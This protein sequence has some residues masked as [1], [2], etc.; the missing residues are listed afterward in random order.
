MLVHRLPPRLRQRP[1]DPRLGLDERL[2]AIVRARP[3]VVRELLRHLTG[4][5]EGGGKIGTPP[6]SG[7]CGK[8]AK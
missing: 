1:V 6:W 8:A 3:L 2:D 4:G 5:G 7:C